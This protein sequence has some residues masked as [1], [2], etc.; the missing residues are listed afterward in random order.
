MIQGISVSSSFSWGIR[1][2][3]I[4]IGIAADTFH[5]VITDLFRI[6]VTAVTFPAADAVPVIQYTRPV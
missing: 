5:A 3:S 4:I 6:Q 2:S 1:M